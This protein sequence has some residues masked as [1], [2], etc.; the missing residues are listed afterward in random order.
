MRTLTGLN[1]AIDEMN[2]TGEY[3]IELI[4]TDS[5]SQVDKQISDVELS[6]IHI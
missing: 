5:Q 4:Y 6:L 1:K 2:A 3:D